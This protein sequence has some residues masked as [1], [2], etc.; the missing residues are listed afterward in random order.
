MT[1]QELAAVQLATFA[2]CGRLVA[3][4]IASYPERENPA[5]IRALYRFLGRLAKEMKD[6]ANKLTEVKP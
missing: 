2:H 4:E 1:E 3:E 6:S 5:A